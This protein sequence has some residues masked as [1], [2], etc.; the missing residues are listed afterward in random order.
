MGLH[1]GSLAGYILYQTKRHDIIETKPRTSPIQDRPGIARKYCRRG[2]STIF[3][4]A[5]R[6]SGR[7]RVIELCGRIGSGAFAF[8][9]V[10]GLI[11]INAFTGIVALIQ[12][13]SSI[14]VAPMPCIECA[15]GGVDAI[16]E[17][18]ALRDE[19]HRFMCIRFL[20]LLS[21]KGLSI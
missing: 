12:F 20:R 19:M 14:A 18:H 5:D 17:S 15:C 9:L 6:T 4:A 1:E 16:H 13:V 7:Q 10:R 3:E 21:G 2:G 11:D 8:I